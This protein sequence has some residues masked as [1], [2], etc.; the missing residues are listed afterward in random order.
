VRFGK[1]LI[2]QEVDGV[3]PMLYPLL[4]GDLIAQG[5]LKLIFLH[6]IMLVSVTRLVLIIVYLK[7]YKV[8]LLLSC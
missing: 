5:Q 1:T 4:R 2:I 3:E 7:C 8:S 6:Y